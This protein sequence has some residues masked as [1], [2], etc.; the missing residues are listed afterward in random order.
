[1]KLIGHFILF[2]MLLSCRGKE[3]RVEQSTGYFLNNLA[4][5]KIDKQLEEASGIVAS[6]TNPGMFW[7]INDSGHPADVFLIDI[8]AQIRMVCHIKGIKNRDWEDITLGVIGGKNFIYV[9]DIGDNLSRY[10]S[11]LIYRF[12]EPLYE[13]EEV[14]I[15]EVKTFTVFL[16]DGERDTEAMMIDPLTNDLY[17]VSKWEDSVRLYHAAFP[18]S[19][20][21]TVEKVAVLPYSGIVAANI[22]KDG[23]EVLMKDY[24]NVYYWKREKGQLITDLL[25]QPPIALPYDMEEQGEAICFGVDGKGYYT[26]SET[27]KRRQAELLFYKRK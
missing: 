15:E 26:V 17:L 27:T 25:K 5:G 22:S 6:V 13:A 16:S 12:E 11:K 1:M 3:E 7:V 23:T 19:D 18:F 14:L 9:G 8:H 20:T 10:P 24:P 4:L 21:L 2:L